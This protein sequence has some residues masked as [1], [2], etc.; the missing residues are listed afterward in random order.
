MKIEFS[1]NVHTTKEHL[2]T[3]DIYVCLSQTK[4]GCYVS[5]VT[6]KILIPGKYV[7]AEQHHRRILKKVSSWLM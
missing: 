3:P 7:T 4:D 2:Q 1:L 5:N 6:D